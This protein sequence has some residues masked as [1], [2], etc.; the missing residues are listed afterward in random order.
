MAAGYFE[1]GK[2]KRRPPSNSPSAA[3]RA[4]RNYV[5]AAGLPEVVELP[6]RTSA[7]PRKRSSIGGA[8]RSSATSRRVS[9]N[10]CA[11]SVSPAIYSL[12]RKGRR[13]MRGADAAAPRS[14]HRSADTG[15][16]LA[17]RHRVSDADRLQGGAM[18]GSRGGRAVVEFGTRRAHTPKPACW[19]RARRTWAAAGTSNTLAGSGYGIPVPAPRRTPG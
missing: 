1:A 4:N 2:A 12:F 14:H 15:N 11:A 18:R 8:C 9:S 16:L 7:S 3:C 13:S 5:M 6:A 19:A 10:T 17:C